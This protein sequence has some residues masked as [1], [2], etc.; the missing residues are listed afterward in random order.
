MMKGLRRSA[1]LNLLNFAMQ[2]DIGKLVFLDL[3]Q[4]FTATLRAN[5]DEVAHYTDNITGCGDSVVA[6]ISKEFF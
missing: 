6:A 1:G 2:M 5:R 3:L 4:W